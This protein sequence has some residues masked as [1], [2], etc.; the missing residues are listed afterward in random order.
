M[1]VTKADSHV[2]ASDIGVVKALRQAKRGKDIKCFADLPPDVQ[3]TINRVSESNEE[4]AK[5]T[6]AAIKYQRLFPDNYEPKDVVCSGVVTSKPG[7]ADYN[8]VCTPE[9][10][11]ERGR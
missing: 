8:G 3:A 9:W 10:R 1:T 2:D 11:A 5:R 6:A 4:K 7:D